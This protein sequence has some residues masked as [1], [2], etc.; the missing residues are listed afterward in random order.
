M[1][2]TDNREDFI[3]QKALLR[4]KG[5]FPPCHVEEVRSGLLLRTR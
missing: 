5:A 3:T 1:N 4:Y 2:S